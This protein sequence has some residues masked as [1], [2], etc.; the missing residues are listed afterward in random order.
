MGRRALEQNLRNG[1]SLEQGLRNGRGRA[2]GRGPLGQGLRGGRALCR[3]RALGWRRA[4]RGRGGGQVGPV[5]VVAAHAGH[6]GTTVSLE[7]AHVAAGARLDLRH[8]LNLI[9][10]LAVM[11]ALG[12]AF[13]AVDSC[14]AFR[15]HFWISQ[16]KTKL[17]SRL[18][19]NIVEK[20]GHLHQHFGGF[21]G[22][23][24]ELRGQI[25][26]NADMR[27]AGTQLQRGHQ[28]C[29]LL[30]FMGPQ[31]VIFFLRFLDLL[32]DELCGVQGFVPSTSA[33]LSRGR[34]GLLALS[35]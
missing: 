3:G 12:F 28:I 14:A 18:P 15:C 23:L 30:Y 22:G 19:F 8:G 1:R 31:L 32:G 9:T 34:R 5:E 29:P 17:E 20:G 10:A 21:E 4:L 2:L 13:E 7:Q 6:G 27:R 24:V 35:L 26:E 33:V 25:L 16:K 11:E